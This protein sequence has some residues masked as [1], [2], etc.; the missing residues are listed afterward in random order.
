[1]RREGTLFSFSYFPITIFQ[2]V[3]TAIPLRIVEFNGDLVL[4][5]YGG[6]V[7]L[8]IMLG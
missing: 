5:T 6:P 2:V 3:V 8:G 7:R 4:L 1:M